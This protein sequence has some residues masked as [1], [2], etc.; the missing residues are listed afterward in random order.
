[1]LFMRYRVIEDYLEQF[2]FCCP[3]AKHTTGEEMLN[4]LRAGLRYIH[5]LI[6]AWK[7]A[8]FDC[9]NN[10]LAPPPI[11][12]ENCLRAQT[13]QPVFKIALENN[14]FG[15]GLHIFCDW[16]HKW[17]SFSVI[18]AHVAWPRA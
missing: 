18:L 1:M 7:T 12:L 9:L 10:T 15:W 14:F 5:T 4:T 3:L 6:S 2:I 16:R 8:V 11:A 17:S 13:D